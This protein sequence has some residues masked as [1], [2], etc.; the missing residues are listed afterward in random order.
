MPG[1]YRQFVFA[2][3]T[4][5]AVAASGH[6]QPL[7][8]QVDVISHAGHAA[9]VLTMEER[10]SGMPVYSLDFQIHHKAAYLRKLLA[11]LARDTKDEEKGKRRS[12]AR[13]LVIGHS[14]GC[15]IA[16]KLAAQSEFD[17]VDKFVLLM[18][19]IQWVE[20]GLSPLVQHFGI[21]PAG[22]VVLG[23]LVD[24]MPDSLMRFL[25][26]A[27]MTAVDHCEWKDVVLTGLCR[28]VIHNVFYMTR[29]EVKNVRDLPLHLLGAGAL[30]RMFFIFSPDN[31]NYTPPHL[32][33][34]MVE[35]VPEA[36]VAYLP[37]FVPHAFV[38]SLE[39]IHHVVGVITD[40]MHK[41][42]LFSTQISC[43]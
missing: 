2:L 11:E 17:D 36:E 14:I 39:S 25:V 1:F 13:V 40:F 7:D 4:S 20:Q 24:R 28:T 33:A 29:T 8:I 22:L 31:D 18:P 41:K 34:K 19:V 32:I 9:E 43:L 42:A 21:T 26:D 38:Q 5:F 27:Q 15:L 12:K 3:L 37:S 10:R 30:A 16:S 6:K 35:C 23:H